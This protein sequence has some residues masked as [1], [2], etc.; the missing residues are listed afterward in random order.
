MDY[1]LTCS[2]LFI[3]CYSFSVDRTLST[4]GGTSGVYKQTDYELAPL[5][6]V[7][8]KTSST[9]ETNAEKE[10]MKEPEQEP[11]IK[12]VPIDSTGMS[13]ITQILYN[14]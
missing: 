9:Y 10:P 4:S 14:I 5:S 3:L 1:F 7:D 13:L 11:D 12:K 2:L 8:E 6:Q